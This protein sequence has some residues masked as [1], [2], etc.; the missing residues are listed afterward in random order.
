VNDRDLLQ[1]LKDVI[2]PELGIDIVELG[3]V[4]SAAWRDGDIEVALT[5]STPS[6][7]LAEMFAEEIQGALHA[8]FPHVRSVR[9]E[10]V[11]DPPWSPA[12]LSEAA[13][14]QLGL[15]QEEPG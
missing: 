1:A 12:R 8:R 13:R 11:W 4:C 6:C 5:P 9:V 7:P 14:Q 10:L 2:D 15:P 3:L